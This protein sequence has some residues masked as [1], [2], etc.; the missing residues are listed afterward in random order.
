MKKSGSDPSLTLGR[1]VL[2]SKKPKPD[3][4][5][6]AR[7]TSERAYVNAVAQA[8]SW[9]Q[10]FK[11]WKNLKTF[12]T[13]KSCSDI[14]LGT[15]IESSASGR[16]STKALRPSPWPELRP[17]S[18]CRWSGSQFYQ[19]LSAV[20]YKFTNVELCRFLSTV[21]ESIWCIRIGRYLQLHNCRKQK[22][23]GW[24]WSRFDESVVICGLNWISV[25]YKFTNVSFHIFLVQL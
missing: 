2:S 10:H 3:L 5:A 13:K 23:W 9:R 8:P 4:R 20:I 21:L 25:Y 19:S 22:F 17:P 24:S 12:S 14:Q 1:W 16:K 18:A 11:T 7:P 6:Q 15:R